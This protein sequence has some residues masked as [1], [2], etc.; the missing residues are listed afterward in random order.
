MPRL[1][2][3]LTETRPYSLLYVPG[4]VRVFA[5]GVASRAALSVLLNNRLRLLLN[6]PLPFADDFPLRR[7]VEPSLLRE[8]VKSRPEWEWFRPEVLKGGEGASP[9]EE[10]PLPPP[11]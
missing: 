11:H 4:Q 8:V 9:P 1:A 6:R 10:S 2:Q 5:R 3:P 7:D